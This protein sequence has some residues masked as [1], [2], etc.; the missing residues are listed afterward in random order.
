MEDLA[1]ALAAEGAVVDVISSDPRIV[2]SEEN[3]AHTLGV[4]QLITVNSFRLASSANRFLK[5]LGRL[6][7][8]FRLS[9]LLDDPRLQDGYDLAIF[10]SVG[11]LK[12]RL[13]NRLR[14]TGRVEHLVFVLWDFFPRHQIEI[15][16]LPRLGILERPLARLER[17]SFRHADTVALMSP[18]NA[19]YF[20][21]YHSKATRPNHIYLHPWSASGVHTPSKAM[22]KFPRFTVIFGGQ[23]APG[24]DLETLIRA[25]KVSLERGWE[26]D[27]H[28]AG[29]GP[30]RLALESFSKAQ[31]TSNVLFLGQLDRTEYRDHAQRC[32]IGVSI[33]TPGVSI[34]SFP[35]KIAE[36]LG[37]GLPVIVAHETTSDVGFELE[38]TKA[39]LGVDSGNPL[40]LADAI[41]RMQVEWLRDGLRSRQDHALQAWSKEFSAQSAARRLLALQQRS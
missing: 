26:I 9:S 38:M 16:M 31:K 1:R 33:T 22:P 32:H 35:S 34:P 4:R 12:G 3:Q 8:I 7:A 41:R 19:D 14:R 20:A 5:N 10:T 30:N 37:L 36:F 17:E 27:I 13:P 2:P 21:R 24:R 18:R 39:G 23:L 6:H 28:I 11:I 40:S 15:G 29:D 25:A